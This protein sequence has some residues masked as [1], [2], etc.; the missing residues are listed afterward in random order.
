MFDRFMAGYNET[1]AAID[2][3]INT[4]LLCIAIVAVASAALAYFLHQLL[5]PWY[6]WPGLAMVGLLAARA[7]LSLGRS[8]R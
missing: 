8:S 6:F 3:V 1:D 2:G 4:T 5:S 7:F